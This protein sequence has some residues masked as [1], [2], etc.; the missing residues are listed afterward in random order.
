MTLDLPG[1]YELEAMESRRFALQ[2]K[3]AWGGGLT[4][5]EGRELD[6]LNRRLGNQAAQPLAPNVRDNR[7]TPRDDA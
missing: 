6:E 1:R 4:R 2:Q 5:L 7:E 3:R